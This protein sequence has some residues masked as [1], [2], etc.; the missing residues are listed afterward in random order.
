MTTINILRKAIDSKEL[1]IDERE[2]SWLD[3]M[4][5]QLLMVT[6][7]EEKFTKEM[8]ESCK[9]EKFDPAKYDL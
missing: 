3:T 1:T 6:D 4:E 5:D 9:S 2:V 8:I 7:D